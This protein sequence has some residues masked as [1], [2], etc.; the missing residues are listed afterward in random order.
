MAFLNGN[1]RG[2]P[3][4]Q[5]PDCLKYEVSPVL[6]FNGKLIWELRITDRNGETIRAEPFLTLPCYL[7]IKY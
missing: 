1:L 4:P 2:I 5:A 6:S 7:K 3:G